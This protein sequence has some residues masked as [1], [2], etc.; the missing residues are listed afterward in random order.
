MLLNV[1]KY[2]ATHGEIG[3]KVPE[4]AILRCGI[5]MYEQSLA[6]VGIVMWEGSACICWQKMPSS[7]PARNLLLQVSF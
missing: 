3:A 4:E 6:V 7:W 1:Q 5:G 2:T